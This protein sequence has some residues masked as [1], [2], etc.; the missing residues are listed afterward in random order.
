MCRVADSRF[1][2][3]RKKYRSTDNDWEP[4]VAGYILRTSHILYGVRSGMVGT[5]AVQSECACSP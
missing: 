4:L 5:K 1:Q 3:F 2:G